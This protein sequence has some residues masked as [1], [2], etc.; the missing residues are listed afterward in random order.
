MYK[1]IISNEDKKVLEK[2]IP[3]LED[4][5]NNGD[6]DKLQIQIMNAIDKTLDLEEEATEDTYILEAIADRIDASNL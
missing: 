1:I 4:F 6:L 2:I 5:I 3:N